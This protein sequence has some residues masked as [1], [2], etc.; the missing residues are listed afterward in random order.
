MRP[1]KDEYFMLMAI[2][3]R[4][5][6]TCH[7][8]RVNGVGCVIASSSGHILCTGYNGSPPGEEHC[9]DVGHH[10]ISGRCVRTIHAEQNAVAQA[11]KHGTSL[12]GGVAYTTNHPCIDCAKLLAAAGITRVV[13]LEGYRPETD[14]ICASLVPSVKFEQLSIGTRRMLCQRPAGHLIVVEGIDGAGKSTV[15]RMMAASMRAVLVTEPGGTQFGDRIRAAM[16][17]LDERPCQ[18][19]LSYAFTAARA[20]LMHEVV[21]PA[22]ERGET[23]VSDRSFISSM[24]YQC[25]TL[26]EMA[27]SLARDAPVLDRYK[28]WP[29]DVVLLDLPADVAVSRLSKNKEAGDPGG[30]DA[31]ALAKHEERR[32]RYH[33]AIE[34][35]ERACGC[36]VIKLDATN[37][38]EG[39]AVEA[40]FSC[41]P[42]GF[43]GG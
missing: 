6:A 10:L 4:S 17:G 30:Y 13:Y 39:I 22:L 26:T 8:E 41:R 40:A 20:Q 31:D 37:D 21:G 3:A 18:E 25:T 7:N 42:G 38:P 16:I 29:T 23:V 12:V 28:A 15:A 19:A 1:S 36:D 9:D 5:R 14:T 32:V 2:V 35:V 34:L 43:F 27:N 11:A 33:T 24:A